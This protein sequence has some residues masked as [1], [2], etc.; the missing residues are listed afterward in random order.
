[1]P[2]QE[3]IGAPQRRARWFG[4]LVVAVSLVAALALS[5][6]GET[7]STRSPSGAAASGG[8]SSSSTS[9]SAATG[10]PIVTYTFTD[11]NTQGP[12]YKNIQETSR[13]YASWVN[14]HGGIAGHPLDAKFCDAM[15]T[16]TAATACA[17]KAVADH[18]VA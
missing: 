17:R 12:Q 8:S 6:W 14:A 10:S 4:A 18:A 5:P 16:P 11:V 15:G 9:S 7:C 2:S 1:M 13:V 3:C